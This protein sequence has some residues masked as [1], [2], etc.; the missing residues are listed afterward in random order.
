[1][2]AMGSSAA[3]HFRATTL[4]TVIFGVFWLLT[5]LFI[6]YTTYA[7]YCEMVSDFG[8]FASLRVAFLVHVSWRDVGSGATVIPHMAFSAKWFVA[9]IAGT[10]NHDQPFDKHFLAGFTR[11]GRGKKQSGRESFSNAAACSKR[12]NSCD[13][14]TLSLEWHSRI[15]LLFSSF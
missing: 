5:I 1:M 15:S 4:F 8:L 2:R 7:K 9:L 3:L 14:P 13:E 10:G 6:P 11:G 12:P